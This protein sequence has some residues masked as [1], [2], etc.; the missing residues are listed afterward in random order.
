MRPSFWLAHSDKQVYMTSLLT[1][2]IGMGPAATVTAEV[3]DRH[4]FRGSYSGKD[5]IPLWRDSG[6]TASNV[7]S[8][9]IESLSEVYGVP[10]SPEDLFAY[11]YGVLAP[12][13]YVARFSEELTVPGPRLPLTKD[14]DLF[15]QIS[16][17]G[18]QFVFLHSYAERFLP[19]GATR[20]R[21]PRGNAQLTKAIPTASK[22]YPEKFE[23]DQAT[24]TLT[25]GEGEIT[26]VDPGVW[27]YSVSGLMVVHSWL[28]Y[29]MKGGAGRASS[30]LDKVRPGQWTFQMTQ[31]LLELL[32]VL[33]ATI[34]AQAA[35]VGLLDALVD[36]DLFTADDL[37]QPS[38]NER[39]APVAELEG[40]AVQGE[41]GV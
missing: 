8:G 28:A 10:V 6:A 13:G 1:G 34:A 16:D 5:V 11:A 29:R 12:R 14:A 23:Y 18:R 35:S 22:R 4:H 20:G 7:T 26:P 17:L 31:E 2:V 41:L 24:R 37:P 33:E 25:V 32:W 21:V 40:E 3:P 36:S 15:K 19:A 30:D 9:L 27:N 38:Q 39:K